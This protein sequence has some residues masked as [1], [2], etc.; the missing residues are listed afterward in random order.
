MNLPFDAEEYEDR[1]SGLRD[2]IE[3]HGLDGVV[4]TSGRNLAYFVG[5]LPDDRTPAACVVT[6]TGS[7]VL[8][9]AEGPPCH[10]DRTAPQD[11]GRDALWRAIAAVTGTGRALGCEAD[12]LTMVQADMLNTILRP[13]RGMDI[14]PATLA[15][16]LVKSDA[17]QAILRQAAAVADLGAMALC[18]ALRQGAAEPQAARQALRLA[19]RAVQDELDLRYPDEAG[20]SARIRLGAMRRG[21]PT[22]LAVT[23]TVHG[24]G[25]PLIRTIFAG[26]PDPASLAAWR[27]L[28]V[29]R[30]LGL[31]L[32]RPGTT[33]SA[34]AA[35]LDRGAPGRHGGSIGLSLPGEAP[36]HALD[37]L[38]GNDTPLEP[39]M[40]IVLAPQPDLSADP[41]GAGHP[42]LAD[43]VIVTEDGAVPIFSTPCDLKQHGP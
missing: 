21:R 7:T 34:V 41:P 19:A 37:L 4:L 32:L 14:S 20:T 25:A 9:P 18:A 15:Q 39:G 3:V 23:A 31:S 42:W 12:H 16:R 17:E 22:M 5:Y 13:K 1:L 10:G 11:T 2:L 35:A 29:R 30:D 40:A 26:E 36:D 33:C 8:A 6:A 43:A 24:Y 27:A 28:M 38:A